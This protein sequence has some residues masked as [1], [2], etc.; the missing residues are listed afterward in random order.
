MKD[1]IKKI[2]TIKIPKCAKCKRK[3]QLEFTTELG[4][5]ELDKKK[6]P[7]IIIVM[8]RCKK[9][10]I[11]YVIS[12]VKTKDIPNSIE[13]LKKSLNKRRKN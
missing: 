1:K 3:L 9:C 4:D 12:L 8:G 7:K 10:R 2:I 11:L 13:E 5:R 6:K